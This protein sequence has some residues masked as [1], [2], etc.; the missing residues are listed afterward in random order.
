MYRHTKIRK[1]LDL[2]FSS[3]PKI[4]NLVIV[5]GISDHD[6]ITFYLDIT[7]KATSSINQHKDALYHNGDFQS[8]KNNPTSFG[9]II[10][11]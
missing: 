11:Q 8:I 1:I 9:I 5:P 2:F 10:A 7:H 6:V 3:H 4:S